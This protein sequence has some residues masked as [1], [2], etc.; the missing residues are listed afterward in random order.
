LS[1]PGEPQGSSEHLPS[2][3]DEVDRKGR[4]QPHGVV[5]HRPRGIRVQQRSKCKVYDR[6]GKKPAEEYEPD[7][8]RLQATC[9]RRGGTD[10]ACRWISTIFKDGVTLEALVR[11]LKLT[12]IERMKFPGGFKPS[13]A[14]DG[15]LQEADDVF[16]CCLCTVDMRAS[17]KNK[18][19]AI[20][21]LRKF[22]LGL[23][24]QCDTW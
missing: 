12:E 13:L 10:F 11:P 24:D 15:F 14:Y 8:L 19:D 1:T 21:H 17:W 3:P 18:K 2:P 16:E 4:P 22:H 5:R 20:R 7:P 23:A 6:P 9:R